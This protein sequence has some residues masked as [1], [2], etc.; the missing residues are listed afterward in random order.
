MREGVGMFTVSTRAT[1]DNGCLL[2]GNKC[3]ACGLTNHVFSAKTISHKAAYLLD[4]GGMQ[5][6]A[7]LC[8]SLA[9]IK[10]NDLLLEG[11]LTGWSNWKILSLYLCTAPRLTLHEK[12]RLQCRNCVTLSTNQS[13][14]LKDKLSGTIQYGCAICTSASKQWWTDNFQYWWIAKLGQLDV[15]KV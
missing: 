15:W 5:D 9:R 10:Q 6:T 8:M 3:T 7:R 1:K 11:S 2:E 13:A 4:I 14:Q 12:K